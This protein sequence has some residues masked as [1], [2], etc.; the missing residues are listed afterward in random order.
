MIVVQLR[1]RLGRA[2][3]AG[4]HAAR[5]VAHPVRRGRRIGSVGSAAPGGRV[6]TRDHHAIYVGARRC[7]QCCIEVARVPPMPFRRGP[8]SVFCG[9]VRQKG[10]DMSRDE[11][12]VPMSVVTTGGKGSPLLPREHCFTPAAQLACEA[13]PKYA[14]PRGGCAERLH[15][16][17]DRAMSRP[18][19]PSMVRLR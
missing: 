4:F 12:S 17:R 8:A 19:F 15:C 3:C 6:G 5:N 16:A 1:T 10:T 14:A 7:W 18:R 13:G 9:V 2:E 11:T